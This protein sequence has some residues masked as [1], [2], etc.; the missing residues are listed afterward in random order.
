MKLHRFNLY[1]NFKTLIK[2]FFV[3]KKDSEKIII[4]NLKKITKKKYIVL[5]AMCRVSFYLILNYLRKNKNKNEIIMINYNLKE[6]TDIV[7][8]CGFKLVFINLNKNCSINFKDLKSKISKRTSAIVCTNMFNNLN[9]TL[10]LKKICKK[11]KIYLIE[12]NAI[13]YGNNEILN[14]KRIYSGSIGDSSIFSFGLMKRV[15]SIDGGAIATN[16]SR[17]YRYAQEFNNTNNNIYIWRI[18]KQ[19]LLFIII[20]IIYSKI[21]YVSF[22]N[23]IMRQVHF[24]DLKLFL[25]YIY[26][27][28]FYS[29]KKFN[30]NLIFR[31]PSSISINMVAISMN[32]I[33]NQDDNIRLR[34]IKLYYNKLKKIKKIKL[35]YNENSTFQNYLDFPILTNNK[36]ALYEYLFRKGIECKLFFYKSCSRNKFSKNNFDKK[37]ICL[38]CHHNL[39]INE[40]NYTCKQIKTFYDQFR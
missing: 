6:M 35:I 27:A 14:N 22:F 31:K 30:T 20:K 21:F 38:P 15:S 23:F 40:I 33:N 8:F 34:N 4:K 28:E 3:D 17:L 37:I 2:S 7:T 39:S 11:N 26:P 32:E 24:L 9:D 18:I 29:K 25:K 13:Y 1:L 12:D 10:K 19:L 16:D 36:K 5:T